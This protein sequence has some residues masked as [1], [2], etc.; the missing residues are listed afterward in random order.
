MKDGPQQ[1]FQKDRQGQGQ[2][3]RPELFWVNKEDLLEIEFNVC[4][5]LVPNTI[6][7]LVATICNPKLAWG[8]K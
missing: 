3:H 2:D 7:K 6:G 8:N 5:R 1:T 4:G